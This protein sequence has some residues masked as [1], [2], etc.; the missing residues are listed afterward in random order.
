V[1]AGEITVEIPPGFSGNFDAEVLRSGKIDAS[2]E[3]LARAGRGVDPRTLSASAGGG[4]AA[5]KLT[6]G[7]GVIVIK[8]AVKSEE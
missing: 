1:A 5:F 3:E 4:G 7:D 8:K 2:Y 6:V